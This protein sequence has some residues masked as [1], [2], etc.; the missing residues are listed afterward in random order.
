MG[1]LGYPPRISTYYFSVYW[2]R[3]SL[4]SPGWSSTHNLPAYAK[5]MPRATMPPKPVLAVRANL[6]ALLQTGKV[7]RV[8][9]L[10]WGWAFPQEVGT[11]P[12]LGL[13]PFSWVAL[14]RGLDLSRLFFCDM[15]VCPIRGR[16]LSGK[17]CFKIV[18]FHTRKA[19]GEE[20]LRD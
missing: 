4:C 7:D 15:A 8:D 20:S 12:L 9:S 10:G 13:L 16:E 17:A 2:Y 6:K 5:W 1:S 3:V 19:S 18:H 11:L 14:G